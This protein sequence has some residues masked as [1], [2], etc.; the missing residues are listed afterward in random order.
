M[1]TIRNIQDFP[2]K[3]SDICSDRC[4]R[5]VILMIISTKGRY[6]LKLM[7]YLAKKNSA[8]FVP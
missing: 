3:F 7:M 1:K 2:D 5:N 4:Q 6:A 8:E